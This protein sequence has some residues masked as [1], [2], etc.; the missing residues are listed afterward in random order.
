MQGCPQS[1]DVLKNAAR[2]I[3][4]YRQ[5]Y[6][7]LPDP[8]VFMSSSVSTSGRVYDDFLL[9]FS[10]ILIVKILIW[11]ENCPRNLISFVSCGLSTCLTLRDQWV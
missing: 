4:H 9:L 1:D 7:D 6:A 8:V 3:L 11:E 10:C 5:L 2:K